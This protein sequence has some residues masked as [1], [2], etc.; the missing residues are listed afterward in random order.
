MPKA[1]TS[2]VVK[3]HTGSAFRA[4][5]AEMNGWRPNMEDASLIFMRETWGFFGVFDGH[6]GDQC[7]AFIARRLEEELQKGCPEDDAALSSLALR[8]D[9]E[10]LEGGQPSGSTGTFVIVKLPKQ[11]GGKYTLRVGNIGDSRVLLGNADGSMFEGPG[12]DGGL[13]TDHKPDHPGERARIE[14][15]GGTVQDVMGVARVNGDLAVSRAFGDAQHK[16]TGGPAQAEHPVSAE[17]ELTTLECNSSDF[18]LLVCDGISEGTFP[19]REVVSLAAEKL[20]QHGDPG[21]AATAVC[22]EALRQGSKDNL[23]C[24][25]VLLSG[26]EETR[27]TELIPGPFQAPDHV[28]FQKAYTSMAEHA[29]RTLAEVLELRYDYVREKLKVLEANGP[30][31]DVDGE[32]SASLQAELADFGDGP[33]DSLAPGSAERTQWFTNWLNER[34]NRDSAEEG[35]AG[36]RQ[37]GVS[38]TRD[39]FLGMLQRNPQLLA[40]VEDRGLLGNSNNKQGAETAG[41]E[42]RVASLEELKAAVEDHPKLKWDERLVD[43]C[44]QLGTVL[45][46]DDSDG[47]SQVTFKQKRL[48]AWLPTSMLTDIRSKVLV[49][50]VDELRPAVEAHSALKWDTR[51]EDLCQQEGEILKVDDADGT[52]RVRF[53]PPL[54]LTAWLPTSCLRPACGKRDVRVAS[55]EELRSAVQAH[56]DCEWDERM[57]DVCDTIGQIQEVNEAGDMSQV[58]FPGV[59]GYIAW[60]PNGVLTEVADSAAA[61]DTESKRQRTE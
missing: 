49:A 31:E 52:S 40:M 4:A 59:G 12:T 13:T 34:C 41:R 43:V 2:V 23:S 45:R 29:G 14:R 17:P 53:P 39:Q 48:T 28:G 11:A 42:V 30:T 33:A 27:D 25:I 38:M 44:E 16:K 58:K 46:D 7:S 3:R 9:A 1:V 32:T 57:T 35:E 54:G 21:T 18:L 19:N 8:L 20:R 24:M 22:R 15:T 60:L 55:L 47:T 51:L 50:P 6:G 10:F 36:D 56:Q 5:I 26:G 37:D 61:D